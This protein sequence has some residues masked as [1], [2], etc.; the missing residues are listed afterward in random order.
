MDFPLLEFLAAVSV[1]V[2]TAAV[3]AWITDRNLR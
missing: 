3:T 2:V 1:I